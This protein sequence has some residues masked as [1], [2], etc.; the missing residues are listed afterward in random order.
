VVCALSG[1]AGPQDVVPYQKN[2]VGA[3]LVGEALMRAKDTAQFISELLGGSVKS[4]HKESKKT[5][6][7]KIC[8]TRSPEAAKAA[9][10][11]GADFIGIILV[12]GRKRC[13]S[14][15]TALQISKVI[16]E[17]PRAGSD[18]ASSEE[19]LPVSATNY[20]DHTTS[21]NLVHPR[22]ASLVGVFQ[23]QPLSYILEQQK[24]LGL[25]IVQLHGSEP[26][27]WASLI[28]V[29]VIRAF[30]PGDAGLATRGYH[31]LP[32]VD[33][34]AGGSGE[35][36]DLTQV[37]ELLQKD[38]GLRIMLAGGLN[39]DN[40]KQ[41]FSGLA[42]NMSQIAIL[43]VSSGVEE[44]GEQSLSKIREFVTAVKAGS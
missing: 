2:G 36:V 34:G 42:S 30:H 17:T 4:A 1:I 24:L 29:P 8:G 23:N 10:E 26:I 43:D 14:T 35:Q 12:K 21:H 15:E 20:F 37:Q 19:S 6:M 38:S 3:V 7:V 18:A 39:P 13:V 44:N 32:L 16:H 41:V 11:A 22:H 9:V 28:P 5:P 31:A 40:V 33:S 27:E 25:D